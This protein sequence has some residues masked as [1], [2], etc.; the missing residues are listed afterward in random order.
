[1]PDN[2]S[3]DSRSSEPVSGP[4][5]KG[6]LAAEVDI[7]ARLGDR[8]VDFESLHA[9]SNIYRA[10][11]SIR[12]TA[13][14]GILAE[15]NLSWGGFTILWVLWIWND[16][17]TA[18]LAAECDLA[19]GTLTG[20]LSTL[21]KQDLVSRSRLDSDRRKV[22]VRLTP[23]GKRRIESIVP[24]FNLFEAEMTEGLTSDEKQTLSSLLRRVI[25]NASGT[26]G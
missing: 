26:T 1:M 3:I 21:E 4:Q 22:I 18:R 10:A 24:T 5:N 25:T 17:D 23:A 20:M 2:S 6:I 15:A 12:R 16:M 9:V 11:S 19:K 7:Q 13:E 8:S 14:R